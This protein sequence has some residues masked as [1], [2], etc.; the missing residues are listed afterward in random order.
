MKATAL[1]KLTIGSKTRSANY[2]FFHLSSF[3][4][5][6]SEGHRLINRLISEFLPQ[7][8]ARN[9]LRAGTNPLVVLQKCPSAP[10]S[11]NARENENKRASTKRSPREKSR[12]VDT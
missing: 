2:A 3:L 6:L 8:Y 7:K 9:C 10:G 4:P 5:S 1:V 11:P 12:D